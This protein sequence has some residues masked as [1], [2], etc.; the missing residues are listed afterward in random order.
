MTLDLA[1]FREL[2]P[3][4]LRLAHLHRFIQLTAE[5]FLPEAEELV[6]AATEAELLA[7]SDQIQAL[8]NIRSY[9]L[10]LNL[11]PLAATEG[12]IQ[13]DSSVGITAELRRRA[14]ETPR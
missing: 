10:E 8:V 2:E 11:I 9:E 1:S 13:I 3:V 7:E 12:S 6:L 14:A 4:K 5:F